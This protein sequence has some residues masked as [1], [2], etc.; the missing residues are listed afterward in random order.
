[1]DYGVLVFLVIP[2]CIPILI[3][4]FMRE[5]NLYKYQWFSSIV[6]LVLSVLISWAFN[7]QFFAGLSEELA[8]VYRDGSRG[9]YYIMIFFIPLTTSAIV[10]A[11]CHAVNHMRMRFA[12]GSGDI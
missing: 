9:R 12:Q 6:V 4:F 8:G 5:P 11:I 2:V 10:A 1:M 7:P 3:N